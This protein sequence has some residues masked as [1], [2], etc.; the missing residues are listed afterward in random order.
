[1]CRR[2]V[3]SFFRGCILSR[4]VVCHKRIFQEMV[5]KESSQVLTALRPWHSGWKLPKKSHFSTLLKQ[6]LWYSFGAKI[7]LQKEKWI[8]K[9]ENWKWDISG[10]FSPTVYV[11]TL[12][13][14]SFSPRGFDLFFR[15][16]STHSISF[17]SNTVNC[18]SSSMRSRA[19]RKQRL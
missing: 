17:C 14:R 6:N 18:S 3:K 16:V 8:V 9:I 13:W 19:N 10:W 2:K 1:M 11:L 7:Q 5:P 12:S 4:I 15:S